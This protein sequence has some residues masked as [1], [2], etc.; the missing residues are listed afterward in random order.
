MNASVSS[1]VGVGAPAYTE[2]LPREGE[3]AGRARHLVAASL[4]TWHLTELADS[5]VLVV[6][7]LVTNAVQHSRFTSIRVTV[8]R[9]TERTV[10]VAVVDKD[11]TTL[12]ELRAVGPDAECGR[13]LAVVDAVALRWGVD[14]LRWGKRIWADLELEEA[15]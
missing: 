11:R 7:E 9:V 5:A 6:S 12:P 15:L 8:T 2:T 3:S 4:E 14:P 13:G 1:A 10:R